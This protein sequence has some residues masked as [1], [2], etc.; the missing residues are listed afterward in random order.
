MK[1]KVIGR[2]L[3]MVMCW[4]PWC[5]SMESNASEMPLSFNLVKVSYE[6]LNLDKPEAA[7]NTGLEELKK[8]LKEENCFEKYEGYTLFLYLLHHFGSQ[9][10]LV[11]AVSDVLIDVPE[12]QAGEEDA[13]YHE[14][15]S[16][17]FYDFVNARTPDLRRTALHYAAGYGYWWLVKKLILIGAD[18]KDVDS[19]DANALHYAAGCD[20]NLLS[21]DA[22]KCQ[23]FGCC[24]LPIEHSGYRCEVQIPKFLIKGLLFFEA[25]IQRSP[26]L[27]WQFSCVE[28]NDSNNNFNKAYL[29]NIAYRAFIIDLLIK[30]MLFHSFQDKFGKSPHRYA[31][32]SGHVLLMYVLTH[33]YTESS[34]TDKFFHYAIAAWGT[35][36]NCL[37][38]LMHGEQT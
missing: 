11:R 28:E 29:I 12:Q 22:I 24:M 3:T 9:E 38:E 10:K 26:W 32:E 31:Q 33:Q 7:K 5:S 23:N 13:A 15:I 37:N 21:V 34:S 8:L 6:V 27:P 17:I 4:V 36:F 20:K 18:V 35:I 2:F 16:L 30:N 14:R 25:A 19:N 1:S